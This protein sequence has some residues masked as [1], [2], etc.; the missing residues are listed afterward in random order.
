MKSSFRA[1]GGGSSQ[2]TTE[3]VAVLANPRTSGLCLDL[4]LDLI[5][6]EA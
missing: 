3:F 1:V 5:A 4:G 2:T 6:D